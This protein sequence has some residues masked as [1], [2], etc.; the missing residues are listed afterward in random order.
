MSRFTPVA[1]GKWLQESSIFTKTDP[2]L[3]QFIQA[4]H[5]KSLLPVL[6]MQAEQVYEKH[7]Y[8]LGINYSPQSTANNWNR[9]QF[10]YLFIN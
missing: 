8:L 5:W 4:A 1:A 10:E 2:D 9:I 3:I 7:N 6:H